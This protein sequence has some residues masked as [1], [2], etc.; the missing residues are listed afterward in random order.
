MPIYEY[1]CGACKL[2]FERKHG[3]DEEPLVACPECEGKTRRI[4]HSTS[5]IFKG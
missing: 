5:V 2:R 1:E 3:F 4:F